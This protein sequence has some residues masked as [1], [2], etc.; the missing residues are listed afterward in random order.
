[1]QSLAQFAL[2]S[3]CLLYHALPTL[4]RPNLPPFYSQFSISQPSRRRRT[5]RARLKAPRAIP[6]RAQR[7]RHL[8]LLA[9]PPT[10]R[11]RHRR[12]PRRA[13][14]RA[15]SLSLLDGRRRRRRRRCSRRRGTS[16]ARGEDGFVVGG[17]DLEG[18]LG[19]GADEGA[20]GVVW[21]GAGG[22][23]LTGAGG[24]VEGGGWGGG[25]LVGS[26]SFGMGWVGGLDGLWMQGRSGQCPRRCC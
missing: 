22:D 23:G 4:P 3:T 8:R 9:Q 17:A 7:K 18:D 24:G 15:A 13:I 19:F 6:I 1:M 11:V 14:S 25:L 2:W 20:A 12:T 10:A 16:G 26:V 5:L 21:G